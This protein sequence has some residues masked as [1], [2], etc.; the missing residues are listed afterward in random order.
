METLIFFFFVL[1]KPVLHTENVSVLLPD[2]K[3]F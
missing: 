3:V 1:V 2:F